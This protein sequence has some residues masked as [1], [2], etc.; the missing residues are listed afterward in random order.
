MKKLFYL[1]TALS[2]VF[3][4]GCS[5]NNELQLENG[6]SNVE[7]KS[8]QTLVQ[9]NDDSYSAANLE[10]QISL[11]LCLDNTVIDTFIYFANEFTNYLMSEENL[12]NPLDSIQLA[13]LINQQGVN[14]IEEFYQFTSETWNI[15]LQVVINFSKYSGIVSKE[16]SRETPINHPIASRYHSLIKSGCLTSI[17]DDELFENDLFVIAMLRHGCGSFWSVFS[18]CGK[19]ALLT[20]AACAAPNPVT[21]GLA[22]FAVGDYIETLA[23][24]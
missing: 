18:S 17:L 8:E 14:T 22:I 16:L 13:E 15:P 4:I 5:K 24:C 21:I 23:D 6:F 3:I 20:A 10:N 1:L 9:L 12:T 11:P 2:L 19:A 7:K